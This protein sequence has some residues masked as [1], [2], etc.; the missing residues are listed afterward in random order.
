MLLQASRP[1]CIPHA[2]AP[3][4]VPPTPHLLHDELIGEQVLHHAHL[5]GLHSNAAAA[6]GRQGRG[7]QREGP[8]LR[9]F[10]QRP[11]APTA[12]SSRAAEWPAVAWGQNGRGTPGGRLQTGPFGP[13][14]FCIAGA[15]EQAGGCRGGPGHC[16]AAAWTGAGSGTNAASPPPRG[17]PPRRRRRPARAHLTGLHRRDMLCVSMLTAAGRSGAWSTVRKVW[18]GGGASRGGSEE[19][20]ERWS[21]G[22]GPPPSAAG[23]DS[24]V[25]AGFLTR[26]QSMRQVVGS[27]SPLK[28]DLG[29]MARRKHTIVFAQQP[30][31]IEKGPGHRGKL[32]EPTDEAVAG[33]LTGSGGCQ[34]WRT[35]KRAKAVMAWPN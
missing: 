5:V 21:R 33:K 16:P 23:S 35:V 2:P 8:T 27:C 28:A 17:P 20:G 19:G 32:G 25:T 12:A 14:L 10:P 30:K 1:A 13:Y 34:V 24:I 31:W 22:G 6:A 26:D 7:R 29:G 4:P 9:R 15:A 18:G 3:R 11:L